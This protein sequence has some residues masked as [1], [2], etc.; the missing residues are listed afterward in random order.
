MPVTG[1]GNRP[2]ATGSPL[3]TYAR[4]PRD[5]RIGRIRLERP[6]QRNAVNTAMALA[7]R[8]AVS[9][10]EDDPGV[11][12][13]VLAGAGPVF[14][15]GMDLAAFAGGE[16]PGLDDG[17]GFA[18]FVR[19]RRTKPVIAAVQGGAF[20]GGFEIMLA[21]DLAIAATG[22]VFALPEVRRGI[23]P[24]GG[25][26]VRL[27]ARI[28]PVVAREMLLTGAPVTA[29]RAFDLGLLNAVVPPDELEDAAEA[30]AATIA[31]NAPVAIAAAL[32]VCEIAAGRSEADAWTESNRQW[33]RVVNSHDAREGALAFKER[34]PPDW[35]G[36]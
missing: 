22:A 8:D 18:F 21:C 4:S 36:A 34:R 12:V 5:P 25:G 26:A 15:A 33:R 28:P 11:R 1:D 16:S 32:A 7:L 17:D 14:C 10:F 30:L 24:A 6:E 35:R 3:V 29:E 31:D 13:A 19:R 27:P 23:I 20:A 2:A 9:A